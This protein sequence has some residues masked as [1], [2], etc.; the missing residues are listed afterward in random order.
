MLSMVSYK[1]GNYYCIIDLKNGSKIRMNS[2]DNLTP[3]RPESM[4]V[5]ITNKCSG[6][7]GN[8]KN[9]EFCHENSSACGKH[10][11]I[12]NAKFIETLGAYTELAIGGGNPLEHPDL[13][14][15]L[16]KCKEHK[17][18]P[19]MTV[20]QNHFLQNLDFLRMLRDEQLIY[21]LGVS[22]TYVT[23]EL[24]H[25]LSE[26]PNAVVH[27][28]A[29][30]ATDDTFYE[31]AQRNLKILILGYK[32][33]RRGKTV[34]EKHSIEI[35]NN[36]NTLYLRLPEMIKGNWF[37]TISFDNL[38]IKQL[39]PSRL[40]SEEE[41]KQFYMG[42]DAQYTYFI[43]LV[44]NQFASSSTSQIRYPLKDSAVEMFNIVREEYKLNDK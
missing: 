44:E 7:L 16:R 14:A 5:K 28:I 42:D 37:N 33:I 1:N 34:Y 22:V 18:I 24:I 2:L 29:G 4:D 25:Y 30:I 38:A 43:D 19:S 41:Y 36:I 8:G 6:P 35:E 3:D 21:G 26:F 11:D 20:H 13:E 10:G 39:N 15:F 9:C 12:M 32:Q 40:M 17:L 31:L 23:P 27:L